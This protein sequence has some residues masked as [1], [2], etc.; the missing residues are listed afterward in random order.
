MSVCP[1][2]IY[3]PQPPRRLAEYC[4]SDTG[5]SIYL[6][7][8]GKCQQNYRHS[9]LILLDHAA[10]S[11]IY[12]GQL[13]YIPDQLSIASGT[14]CAEE[15]LWFRSSSCHRSH[16]HR[17]HSTSQHNHC[18]LALHNSIWVSSQSCLWTSN[19]HSKNNRSRR[20]NLGSELQETFR[21]N[22]QLTSSRRHWDNLVA[23]QLCMG[24]GPR[25]MCNFL[26]CLH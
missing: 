2:R 15:L 6:R 8:V 10:R 11:C 24:W 3:Y 26:R 13:Q 16:R 21:T 20:L 5:T 9:D 23:C 7:L 19:H 14:S 12:P 17:D 25:S 22:L 4:S 18:Y 1:Q